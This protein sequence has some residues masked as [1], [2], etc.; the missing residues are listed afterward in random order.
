MKNYWLGDFSES[1]D[2]DPQDD[3]MPDDDD[4]ESPEDSDRKDKLTPRQNAL[5]DYYESVVEEFGLFDKSAKS[6]GAHYA[7]ANANPFKKE[8][9]VCSNC[10]FY[11]KNACEIVKGSIEPDAICKLWIIPDDS[12]TARK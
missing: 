6:N 12:I 4:P 1:K 11:A 9:L 10:A 2:P 8:G 5:Y 7:P 3:D